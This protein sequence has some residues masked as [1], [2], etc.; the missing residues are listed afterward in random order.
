MWEEFHTKQIRN[1]NSD[2]LTSATF[3]SVL[4]LYYK[5]GFNVS[6]YPALTNMHTL[7]HFFPDCIH[8]YFKAERKKE[9]GVIQTIFQA[10]K[11]VAI[12]SLLYLVKTNLK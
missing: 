2:R 5:G 3:I 6:F 4:A 11:S 1:E 10:A 8:C 7:T 12:L 9:G